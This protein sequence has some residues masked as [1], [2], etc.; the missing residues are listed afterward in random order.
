M[1]GTER[2]SNSLIYGADLLE[3]NLKIKYNLFYFSKILIF[4]VLYLIL[5][6]E[7]FKRKSSLTSIALKFLYN[8]LIIYG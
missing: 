6:K 1:C 8:C 4:I 3:N 7:P 2:G 5:V